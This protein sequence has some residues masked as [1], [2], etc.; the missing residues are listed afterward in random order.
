MAS[1]VGGQSLRMEAQS[2]DKRS[3]KDNDPLDDFEHRRII[4]DDV[5]DRR[6]GPAHDRGSRRDSV[7]PCPTPLEVSPCL[8]GHQ[9]VSG[10]T[11]RGHRRRREDVG[12]E[13]GF[14]LEGAAGRAR[15]AGGGFLGRRKPNPTFQLCH[16][17]RPG[18]GRPPDDG[19]TRS[20]EKEWGRFGAFPFGRRGR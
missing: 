8:S 16:L 18:R 1:R 7:V 2:M 9:V 3:M 5:A 19:Q 20:T 10:P 6:S 14:G 12:E 13:R 4:L 11:C 17:D 15:P